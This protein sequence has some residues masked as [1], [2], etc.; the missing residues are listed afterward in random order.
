MA[1]ME[2]VTEVAFISMT[3]S[4]SLIEMAVMEPM[5]EPAFI[6]MLRLSAFSEASG[7]YY[8]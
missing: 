8:K 7:L 2:S 5:T 6:S 3:C 4:L 1:A